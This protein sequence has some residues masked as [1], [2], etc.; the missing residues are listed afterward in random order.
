MKTYFGR[1][2]LGDPPGI[3]IER[4]QFRIKIEEDYNLYQKI[5]HNLEGLR[6]KEESKV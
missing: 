5:F 2:N 3:Q 6:L 4:N 1:L